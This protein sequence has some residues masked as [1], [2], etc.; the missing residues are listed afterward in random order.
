M[1]IINSIIN[2]ATILASYMEEQMTGIY[3][4]GAVLFY[5][6]MEAFSLDEEPDTT[7]KIACALCWPLYLLW[8]GVS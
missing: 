5:W 1:D 2:M 4:A 7:D 6:S 8:L 3:L